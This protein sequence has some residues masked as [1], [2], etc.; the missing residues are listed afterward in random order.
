MNSTAATRTA[1]A[2]AGEDDRDA[3]HVSMVP[4]VRGSELEDGWS[5]PAS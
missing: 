4:P 5:I 2:D 1:P 3:S